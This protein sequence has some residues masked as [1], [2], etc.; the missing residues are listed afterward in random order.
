MFACLE[1]ARPGRSEPVRDHWVH[2]PKGQ[3]SKN[4]TEPV[5]ARPNAL[6]PLNYQRLLIGQKRPSGR[7]LAAGLD[8]WVHRERRQRKTQIYL[9]LRGILLQEVIERSTNQ[10]RLLRS[11]LL[12]KRFETFRLR[13]REPNRGALHCCA[14]FRLA[15]PACS[16]T[17]PLA[18]SVAMNAQNL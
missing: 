12:G 16:C 9:L 10:L 5:L 1:C 2:N 7:S 17:R 11:S 6:V 18:R 15:L 8:R 14:A 3:R 13:T 4:A